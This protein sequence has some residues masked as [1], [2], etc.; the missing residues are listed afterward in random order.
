MK[1]RFK[2]LLGDIMPAA[3]QRGQL[4]IAFT[5][6]RM[7]TQHYSDPTNLYG[8]TDDWTQL[9]FYE[10]AT[11][12]HDIPK[13]SEKEGTNTVSDNYRKAIHILI[14]MALEEQSSTS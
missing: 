12:V 10:P 6:G 4:A 14:G 7:S 9:V 13:W 2:G 3:N 1:N 5:R 8:L 11:L